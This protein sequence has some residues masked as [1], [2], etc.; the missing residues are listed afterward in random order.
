MLCNAQEEA[1]A[2]GLQQLSRPTGTSQPKHAAEKS[3]QL[4]LIAKREKVSGVLGS[5][6]GH[7]LSPGAF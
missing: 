1:R 7:R 5:L 2:P 3:L 6:S 4:L